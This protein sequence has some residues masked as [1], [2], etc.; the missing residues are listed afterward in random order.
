MANNYALFNFCFARNLLKVFA[1]KPGSKILSVMP[2]RLG[3]FCFL[4]SR[5]GQ[6]LLLILFSHSITKCYSINSSEVLS[7]KCWGM[8]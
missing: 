2:V 4:P 6:I 3:K 1:N 8:L 5:N 7:K